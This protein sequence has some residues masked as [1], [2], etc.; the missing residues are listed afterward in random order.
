MMPEKAEG[1]RRKAK[2]CLPGSRH[3][4]MMGAGSEIG[5]WKRVV[6]AGKIQIQ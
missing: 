1:G 6:E 4:G 2:G 3:V 5:K